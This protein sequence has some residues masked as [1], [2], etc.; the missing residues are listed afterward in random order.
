MRGI[1]AAAAVALLTVGCFG[2]RTDGPIQPGSAVTVGLPLQENAATWAMPLDQVDKPYVLQLVE[3]PVVSG[4]EILDIK[5]CEG[6]P[7]VGE[8]FNSCAPLGASWPPSG[9]PMREVAG[10]V[11]GTAPTEGAA[12]LVG[13][14]LSPGSSAGQIEGMRITYVYEGAQ[15]VVDQPWTFEMPST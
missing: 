5:A 7:Q 12:I 8:D 15:Y 13:V 1:F 4:F 10:T 11:V 6:S 9:V 14:R 3:L 2:P